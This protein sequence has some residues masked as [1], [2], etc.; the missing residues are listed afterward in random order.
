MRP[1]ADASYRSLKS[2]PVL[3]TGGGAIIN[4]GSISWMMGA[5]GLIA[6][7]TAKSAV[8]G[9][10]KSLARE[11]GGSAIRVPCIAPGW[12]LT[13][14]QVTS[15]QATAPE[16]FAAYLERQCLKR[17]LAPDD[18]ARLVLWLALD[19]SRMATGQTFILDGGV[20]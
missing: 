18:V 10:S 17:H 8:E 4:F 6:Y 5:A 16:K 20:V 9:L 12:I 19:D 11:L 7:T 1:D 2:R 3:V 13:E 15:A 14:R